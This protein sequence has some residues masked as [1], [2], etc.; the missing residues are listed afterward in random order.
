MTTYT[1]TADSSGNY[2]I[3]FGTAYTGGQKV[4]VTSE[5]DG[6]TKNIELYAPSSVT[7][8]G[9][10]QFSGSVV[11]FPSS[12][13]NI[14]F[15]SDVS[16]AIQASGLRAQVK[17]QNIFYRATGLIFKGSVTTFGDYACSDWRYASQLTLPSTVTT[18]GSYSFESFGYYAT[19]SFDITLP[20][21]VTSIGT[22][23]FNYSGVKNF[24]IGTGVT[25]IPTYAF[26]Y[27]QNLETFNYRN[28][29][30]IAASAFYNS[31]LKYNII[32]NTVTSIAGG[33]F[34]NAQSVEV[35]TGNGI[36]TILALTFG[37]HTSCLKFTIGSAVTSIA[38]NGFTSLT[39]CTELICLPTT[40]P[41]LAGTT[42]LASLST[43]CVIKVPSASLTA[44]QTATNWSTKASQMVGV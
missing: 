5:K 12:I 37:A 17:D 24:D 27:T 20:N 28:V 25:S 40:P 21:A 18:I 14:T 8:G 44:Y 39:A 38:T 30:S 29:T 2:S 33:A 31:R 19:T 26:G 34:N 1:T 3:A 42:G 11:N 43:G 7:G 15:S 6:S 32:P 22:Y 16:G 23:S 9:V 35:H 13:G 41:A 36:T 4:S 10:I